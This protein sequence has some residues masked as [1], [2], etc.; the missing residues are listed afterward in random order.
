M[1]SAN[2]EYYKLP[3]IIEDFCT[4]LLTESTKKSTESAISRSAFFFSKLFSNIIFRT[5]PGNI[6]NLQF[7]G[8]R[9]LKSDLIWRTTDMEDTRFIIENY[10]HEIEAVLMQEIRVWQNNWPTTSFNVFYVELSRTYTSLYEWWWW[11]WNTTLIIKIKHE[12]I[13]NTFLV[14]INIVI[15]IIIS[16]LSI[17]FQ[18]KSRA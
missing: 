18:D 15:I 8:E 3:E 10:L 12:S 11:W 9:K 2:C 17:F 5:R 6:Q 1:N 7:D 4:I 16:L 13:Q 14:H